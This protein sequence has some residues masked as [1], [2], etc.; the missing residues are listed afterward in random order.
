[1]VCGLLRVVCIVCVVG[2]VGGMGGVGGG[3]HV[4]VVGVLVLPVAVGGVFVDVS[5]CV[6]TFVGYV[7]IAS[8]STGCLVLVFG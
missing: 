6:V 3:G 7:A 1:M 8:A 2:D 4:G 5:V